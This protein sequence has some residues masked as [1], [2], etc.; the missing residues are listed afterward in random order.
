MDMEHSA[1]TLDTIK[2]K[3]NS[4]FSQAVGGG[5]LEG[6]FKIIS[7]GIKR[8]SY[9]KA[10]LSLGAVAAIALGLIGF[11]F[12]QNVSLNSRLS[13][14]N[15]TENYNLQSFKSD[16]LVASDAPELR[17]LD[18]MVDYYDASLG[19]KNKVKA[20]LDF[21]RSVYSD[22]LRNLLLPSLNIW[23]NPYTEQVDLSLLGKKYLDNNPYQDVTLLQQWGGII[24][25]SG[26]NIWVNEVVNMQ[27]GEI[28]EE[29]ETGFFHIPISIDFKSDSKRA[30]LLLV[31][32]LSQTSNVNNIGLFND[33]TFHLFE[34]IRDKKPTELATLAQQ[35]KISQISGDDQRIF[36]N[37]V[38]SQ[39]LYEFI[40][41]KDQTSSPLLDAQVIDQVI[42]HSASCSSNE[43]QESCYFRFRDKYRSLPSLAYTIG[44]R[45]GTN[46]VLLLK[47][48]YKN[49]P[50]L[51][52]I[53]SF[54]FD[55]A[56]DT[57]MTLAEQGAYAGRVS[58]K[59]YGRGIS[60]SDAE[61]L[62]QLLTTQCY[63]SGAKA[64]L[65]LESALQKVNDQLSRLSTTENSS[66]GK[67]SRIAN[68][69]E[70]KE[71]FE[72]DIKEYP[73]LS[74]YAQIIKKFEVLRSLK[75]LSLCQQ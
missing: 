64:Q 56:E 66:E 31:D 29:K 52:A 49:I 10:L 14:L 11:A 45:N 27:I 47:D 53:E 35:Y 57:G 17:T 34:V 58:F 72:E 74:P 59:I 70:L 13:D 61:Q 63:G 22:F 54:V 67:V 69:I 12:Y 23:K 7:L 37:K 48:F 28:V 30:F 71:D 65:T 73:N 18:Q 32:K 5:S 21:K 46:K 38:I 2:E 6:K 51:I 39:H 26:Q 40:K 42:R 3:L 15:N 24:R 1:F 41:D 16:S 4:W 36:N 19:I 75:N 55:K 44:Q 9:I 68:L 43:S 60:D 20:E 50:P 8:D 25:D 33:F 62:G